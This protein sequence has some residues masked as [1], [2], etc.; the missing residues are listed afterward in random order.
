L[1]GYARVD[2]AAFYKVTRGVEAQLNVENLFG[3][4]YFPAA[5][6]DNNIAPG[7]PRNAKLT[8]R[9]GL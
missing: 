4:D 6:S 5:H 8:L 7:A 9:F 1:P 3:A 2:A